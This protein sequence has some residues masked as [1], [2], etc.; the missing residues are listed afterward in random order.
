MVGT[1][2]LL[3]LEVCLCAAKG[4]KTDC[5]MALPQNTEV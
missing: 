3:H 1:V 2:L 5:V 4:G